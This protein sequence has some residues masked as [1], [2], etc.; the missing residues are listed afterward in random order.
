[1]ITGSIDLI[2]I[3]PTLFSIGVGLSLVNPHVRSMYRGAKMLFQNRLREPS[4]TTRSSEIR[5]V[6]AALAS[7]GARQYLVI[8]GPKG[9]GKSSI[10]GNALKDRLGGVF[11]VQ[12]SAG[13]DSDT[14]CNAVYSRVAP[15]IYLLPYISSEELCHRVLKWFNRFR[16]P[17]RIITHHSLDPTK[18]PVVVVLSAQTR[19][20][21]DTPCADI[22]SA[23]RSLSEFGF[24]VIVDSSTGAFAQGVKQT[25]HQVVIYVDFLHRSDIRSAFPELFEKVKVVD[26][27][28]EVIIEVVGGAPA[29]LQR[30]EQALHMLYEEHEVVRPEHIEQALG[31]FF[32]SCLQTGN[33]SICEFIEAGF[34]LPD[35][36]LSKGFI[37]RQHLKSPM[38]SPCQQQVF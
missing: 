18:L 16:Q 31:Q 28:Q 32:N 7:L 3:A 15:S 27:A 11:W 4:Y 21:Q 29:T 37:P 23:A 34:I 9:V 12:V 33:S 5:K 19:P 8:D 22:A 20:P 1:M 6:H 2:S 38:S 17:L 10:I 26:G 35:E 14:I 30:I 13:K 25:E 36:I 24:R